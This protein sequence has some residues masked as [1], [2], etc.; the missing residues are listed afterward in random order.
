[1]ATDLERFEK[2]RE[3][4]RIDRALRADRLIA[5]IAGRIIECP[6]C[7]A[8]TVPHYHEDDDERRFP[9]C[10]VCVKKLEEEWEL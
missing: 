8:L 9:R 7:G 1:M 10:K 2:Y 4:E 3:E 6:R 5:L